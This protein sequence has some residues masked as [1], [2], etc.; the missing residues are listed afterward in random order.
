MFN[1]LDKLEDILSRSRYLCGNTFTEADIRL[2]VTLVRH[3]EA[4]TALAKGHALEC[5][6][7]QSRWAPFF[8]CMPLKT[9][10]LYCMLPNNCLS[11]IACFPKPFAMPRG[12]SVSVTRLDA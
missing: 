5:H 1:A 4:C 7:V 10:F 8:Y 12:W 9:P 6:F 11:S 3:D 2:F